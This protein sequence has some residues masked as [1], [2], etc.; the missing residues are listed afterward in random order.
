MTK[1]SIQTNK[2]PMLRYSTQT[3]YD[4]NGLG[5]WL[6]RC[7]T[8]CF[9]LFS[10]S[11]KKGLTVRGIINKGESFPFTDG[12][13]GDMTE[14]KD[15]LLERAYTQYADDLAT[16]KGLPEIELDKNT[17]VVDNYPMKAILAAD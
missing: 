15:S 3:I 9:F 1:I 7:R 11:F 4:H 17:I 13:W 12:K 6:H 16:N 5:N 2:I 8:T 10:A 14:T